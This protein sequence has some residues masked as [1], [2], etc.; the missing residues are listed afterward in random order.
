MPHGDKD[1]CL[2]IENE[3]YP[4][5]SRCSDLTSSDLSTP[6]GIWSA[7]EIMGVADSHRLIAGARGTHPVADT[8][9]EVQICAILD[10]HEIVHAGCEVRARRSRSIGGIA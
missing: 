1:Q 4:E 7:K 9:T 6:C 2:D 3:V 8:R 10:D 5:D